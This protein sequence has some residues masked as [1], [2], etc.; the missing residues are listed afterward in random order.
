[1]HKPNLF[2]VNAETSLAHYLPTITYE[3][4]AQLIEKLEE[5]I[6]FLYKEMDAI[7]C[8]ALRMRIELYQRGVRVD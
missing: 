5:D 8:E 3:E 4:Q 2:L 7:Y 6:H 1:M